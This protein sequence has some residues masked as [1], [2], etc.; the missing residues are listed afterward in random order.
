MTNAELSTALES[1]GCE[2]DPSDLRPDLLS[3]GIRAVFVQNHQNPYVEDPDYDIWA[4]IALDDGR[5]IVQEFKNTWRVTRE[6]IAEEAAAC[7][8]Q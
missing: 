5:V 4:W 8:E 7:T 3:P 1:A 6:A 2:C